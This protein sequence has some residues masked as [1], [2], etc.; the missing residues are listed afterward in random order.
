MILSRR[1]TAR[2]VMSRELNVDRARIYVSFAG[3]DRARA[4]DLVRWL[5]DSGWRVVADDRHA[6]AAGD[7]W[8]PSRR[9]NS[10]DVVLCVITPRWLASEFCR[11][12]F[13][14]SAK[15]GK[16][17][18]PVICELP[19]AGM[20]PEPLRALPR[21]DLTQN[22]LLD[23]L[24]LKE[25]LSQAGSKLKRGTAENKPASGGPLARVLDVRRTVWLLLAV[26]LLI[27]LAAGWLLAGS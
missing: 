19:D 2:T 9:L 14:Y 20:L 12:E 5:N 3:E 25:T 13:S 18:L 23:Y 22:R 11:H 26:A 16:F 27:S 17:V 24:A 21:V 7:R 1:A 6:F 8:S 4:M 10:C 15:R